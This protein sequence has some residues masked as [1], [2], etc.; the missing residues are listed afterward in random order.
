[1]WTIDLVGTDA[2]YAAWYDR[3]AKGDTSMR[4]EM[5]AMTDALAVLW[6]VS[7]VLNTT[8]EDVVCP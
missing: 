4:A 8:G 1:M 5:R 3:E 7:P 6:H 2:K